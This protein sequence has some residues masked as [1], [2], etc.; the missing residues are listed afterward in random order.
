MADGHVRTV[1]LDTAGRHQQ[2]LV[3]GDGCFQLVR[4]HV[5]EVHGDLPDLPDPVRYTGRLDDK[6]E[7]PGIST[8]MLYAVS[9]V[10]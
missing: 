2:R 9:P 4:T 7:S 5:L 1:G 6:L 3:G 8:R 10:L